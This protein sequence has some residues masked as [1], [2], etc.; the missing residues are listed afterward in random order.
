MGLLIC[1]HTVVQY[2]VVEREPNSLP[3]WYGTCREC[4]KRV[5]VYRGYEA[6]DGRTTGAQFG[7]DDFFFNPF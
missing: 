4:G 6:P 2:K 5:D 1:K 3:M 7:L